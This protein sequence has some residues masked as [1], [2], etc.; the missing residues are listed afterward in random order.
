[1]SSKKSK[2]KF[3]QIIIETTQLKVNVKTTG[4]LITKEY[5]LLPFHP[6]MADLRDLSNNSYILFPSFV[7]ITM[8]DLKKAGVGDDFPKV[9]LNLEKYIKLI[10]YVTSPEREADYTLFIDKTQVTNY[11]TA[12]VQNSLTDL[13]SDEASDIISIQ[14]YEPLTEEEIITNNIELIKRLF[15]PLKGH[16]F[17]LGNDYVIGKSKYIPK[18]EA[19]SETNTKL[20]TETRKIPLAYTVRFEVQLLDA[21]NNP[22]AG[23]FLRMS[24]KGKKNS[25]AVDTMDIFGTNFG[26]VPEK[27][28]PVQSI[29]NTSEATKS[30][31][32]G[33]LQKEWEERNKYVKAP[34]NERER[35]EQESKWTPL[36]KK[37]AQYDKYQEVYNKIPPM[38]ITERK[39]LTTKFDN[40]KKEIG[41]LLQD[42]ENIEKSN[43]T[44]DS[45][46]QD[47][48]DDVIDKMKTTIGQLSIN[49]KKEPIPDQ[50][51]NDYADKLS[52]IENHFKELS[53]YKKQYTEIKK[54]IEAEKDAETK[55]KYEEEKNSLVEQ[56]YNLKD[57]NELLIKKKDISNADFYKSVYDADKKIIDDK[58]VKPLLEEA[59]I[60]SKKKDIVALKK[61]ESDIRK[62]MNPSDPYSN[63]SAQAELAKVQG[64]MRKKEA[65]IISLENKFG[66]DEKIMKK[67][68]IKVIDGSKLIKTWEDST[69]ELKK[70]SDTIEAEKTIS[71]KKIKVESINKELDEKLKE[72][73]KLKKDL[74]LAKFFAG[75]YDDLDKDTLESKTKAT[76]RP[77]ESVET[78][79][80]N[81]DLAKNNYLEI[82][83][84][85]SDFNQLQ[86]KITLLNSDL[87][88]LKELKEAKKKGKD[89]KDKE[90][91]E[92][93]AAI[94]VIEK[95][96]SD[97]K[98]EATA[99]DIKQIEGFT[100]DIEL[101]EKEIAE[102][103]TL[104][105]EKTELKIKLYNA[106]IDFLKS[107]GQKDSNLIQLLVEKETEFSGDNGLL[108]DLNALITKREE[109]K[110]KEEY[111]IKDLTKNIETIQNSIKELQREK[112][113]DA[114]RSEIKAKKDQIEPIKKNIS[115]K[116]NKLE[117]EL[118]KINKEYEDKVTKFRGAVIKGGRLLRRTRKR[119]QQKKPSKRYVLSKNKI[120]K[121]KSSRYRRKKYTLRRYYK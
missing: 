91:N 33:K 49:V 82:A 50:V 15:F 52:D 61:Q 7:K 34:A 86:A 19:S 55:K 106:Y 48:I 108:K 62:R 60:D 20:D 54:K 67:D 80:A 29:L 79:Q 23:D 116:T 97:S 104:I 3:D 58:Y 102:K 32:Y 73:V 115:D 121:T 59:N 39:E 8:K 24:C 103:Y 36:Q 4:D 38:W 111:N 64:E 16:F 47:M 2:D 109:E 94:G 69:L 53:D 5:D 65:E 13:L 68:K 57:I 11:A 107:K 46:Q 93:N 90:K 100:K 120:K 66:I 22:D 98:K 117:E 10:K 63:K 1:M 112:E 44:K 89:K 81:L 9:F 78:L 99:S 51:K 6:N 18:Y 105:L 28:A 43:P 31:Q 84:K 14:K 101:I 92:K 27:K 88:D 96:V 70:L 26:Y 77:L 76:E 25:I 12:L 85:F 74:M 30:R 114:I 83:R 87:T 40:F 118:Q 17:I 37:M 21:A 113:T 110:K 71:E 56:I 41:K 119:R 72:I 75:Q 95:R 45:V 42:I 35:L